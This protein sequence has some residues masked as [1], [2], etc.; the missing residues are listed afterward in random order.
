M[1]QWHTL[2]ADCYS[3]LPDD[4]KEGVEERNAEAIFRAG[5]W[6]DAWAEEQ[7]AKRA[8]IAGWDK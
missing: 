5:Q 3:K 1:F 7:R 2:C 8:R 4:L 6:L